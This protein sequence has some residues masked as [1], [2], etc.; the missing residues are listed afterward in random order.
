MPFITEG[1]PMR[2]HLAVFLV[3][4][5]FLNS[6]LSLSSSGGVLHTGYSSSGTLPKT[7]MSSSPPSAFFP[8]SEIT[9]EITFSCYSQQFQFEK[10]HCKINCS[11]I[12]L[13]CFTLYESQVLWNIWTILF[14]SHQ[15]SEHMHQRVVLKAE[16]PYWWSQ[17]AG[18]HGFGHALCTRIWIYRTI[19]QIL[20]ECQS[21]INKNG[22]CN[23]FKPLKNF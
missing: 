8:I 6:K 19:Q 11:T 16:G 20:P 5:V 22:F 17:S 1:K 3:Q 23:N 21:L 2:W 7:S 12:I 15:T 4:I 18:E 10:T 14:R 13:N 9:V